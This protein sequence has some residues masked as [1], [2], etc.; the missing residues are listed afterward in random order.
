MMRMDW[1]VY[2]PQDIL[3]K[4]DRATMAF[5]LEARSPFLDRALVELV[6]RMPRH[7]HFAG[8]R[9]KRLLRSAV[10][11]TAPDF[12]WG[13]RKQGFASPMGHWL[14]GPLGADLAGMIAATDCAWLEKAPALAALTA[15]RNGEGDESPTLWLLYA[16]LAW[17]DRA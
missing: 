3:A 10:R 1:L 8:L 4:V 14:R 15:H 17:R 16:Y 2:L 12:I 7:W 5:G 11:G 13:R 6:L 9:G